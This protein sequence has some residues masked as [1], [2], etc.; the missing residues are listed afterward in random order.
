[1]TNGKKQVCL[2]GVKCKLELELDMVEHL[3]TLNTV[4]RFNLI[5]R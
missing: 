1:M 4:K 2:A 3:G 5:W